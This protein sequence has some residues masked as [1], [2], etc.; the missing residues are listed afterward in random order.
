MTSESAIRAIKGQRFDAQGDTVG[1]EFTVCGSSANVQGGIE[2]TKTENGFAVVWV[3]HTRDT[4]YSVCFDDVKA[5]IY[6]DGAVP[7]SGEVSVNTKKNYGSLPSFP[8]AVGIDGGGL[9]VFWNGDDGVVGTAYSD[10]IVRGQVL[11]PLGQRVGGEIVISNTQLYTGNI[12][13]DAARLT[14]GTIAVTWT[15]SLPTVSLNLDVRVQRFSPDLRQRI[16]NT[17]FAHTGQAGNQQN[18]R[19]VALPNGEY[20]VFWQPT[21]ASGYGADLVARRFSAN[22]EPINY[23]V[24]H[25]YA[26][27]G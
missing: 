18:G 3:T 14:D 9:A 1:E 26:G 23:E 16:G 5:R 20:V 13:L 4:K 7:L 17:F 2:L 12:N 22:G 6:D 8:T 11:S 21:T 19:I 24:I 10:G 25:S 27:R 15:G